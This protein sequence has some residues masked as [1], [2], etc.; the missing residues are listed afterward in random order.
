MAA[1]GAGQGQ[2]ILPDKLQLL[3]LFCMCLLKTPMLR[4]S[5]VRR[6]D[7]AMS[8]TMSPSGDER[9][10]YIY[11]LLQTT[12]MTAMLMVHPN[13]FSVSATNESG[14]GDWLRANNTEVVGSVRM[15]PPL[16][17]SMESLEE[18][19]IYLIDNG[20]AIYLSVGRYVSE[21]TKEKLEAYYNTD[22]T[23][24]N[25]NL[26]ANDDDDLI[27]SI[28][29]LVWQMRAFSSVTRGCESE[30]RPTAWV[31]VIPVIAVSMEGHQQT[32]QSPLE[33]ELQAFLVNDASPAGDKDYVDFLC[34]LHRRIREGLGFT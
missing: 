18:D 30:L 24:Y 19:G 2:L 21:E 14:V 13:V 26:D 33:A 23:S 3:P 16:L 17:P 29:K 10:Y 1:A 8:A 12:P 5:I 25:N 11:H 28:N 20:L 4:N 34:I 22:N 9:A 27:V 7:N 15:P 6:D 32:K 31:P